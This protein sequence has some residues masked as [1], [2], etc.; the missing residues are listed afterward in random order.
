MTKR[1]EIPVLK[2]TVTRG[3]LDETPGRALKLLIGIGTSVQVR[4]AIEQRGFG[5][6]DRREGWRLL[7]AAGDYRPPAG[8]GA[9]APE[10]DAA[11]RDAVVALDGWDEDGF[12]V[13]RAT[14]ERRYPEQAKMVFDGLAASTGASAVLGVSKLLQR[15]D[16][17]EKGKSK[18]DKAAMALL[19]KRG[20]TAA[21]RKRLRDLVATAQSAAPAA[22][23]APPDGD[24]A[25][26]ETEERHV[27]ALVALRAWY[28]EWS[29]I[30]RS[31]IKRRDRLIVL[32]L[33]RRK[34]AAAAPVPAHGVT[35]PGAAAAS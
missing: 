3:T 19:A 32:G 28:E 29:A 8:V 17:L 18:E 6:E 4:G 34:R 30:A 1:L 23:A 11:V 22:E 13:I 35:T 10:V 25:R 31:A 14:L 2:A 15:L 16:A 24:E 12:R 20:V 7:E 5:E 9:G 33:A 26:T 21:E 27:A